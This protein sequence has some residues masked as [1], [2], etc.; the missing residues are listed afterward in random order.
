MKTISWKVGSAR[1]LGV[2]AVL[3]LRSG[4]GKVRRKSRFGSAWRCFVLGIG[5]VTITGPCDE[6]RAALVTHFLD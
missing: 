1:P 5:A 2:L 4:D 6:S 3:A